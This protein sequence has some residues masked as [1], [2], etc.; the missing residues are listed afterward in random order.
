MN[1]NSYSLSPSSPGFPAPVVTWWQGVKL[2]DNTSHI[3][4]DS[5]SSPQTV[6][7]LA[8]GPLTRTN[9]EKPFNCR[10]EN[11]PLSPPLDRSIHVK[12]H[13]ELNSTRVHIIFPPLVSS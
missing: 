7:E 6:N 3:L 13:S 4:N 11:N 2:L 9:V 10:S 8:L 5:R 12:I 1:T